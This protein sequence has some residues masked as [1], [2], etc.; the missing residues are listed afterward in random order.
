MDRVLISLAV[1]MLSG[2][3]IVL[4]IVRTLRCLEEVYYELF[5]DL[6]CWAFE[7]WYNYA[8]FYRRTHSYFHNLTSSLWEF[9]F[10]LLP[11]RLSELVVI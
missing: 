3:V 10:R 9:H 7:I 2:A 4:S 6:Y 8:V 1:M 5:S 11:M